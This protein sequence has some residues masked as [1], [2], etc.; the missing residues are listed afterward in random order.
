MNTSPSKDPLL[1]I[2]K[3]AGDSKMNEINL[4]CHQEFL[5]Q[6]SFWVDYP[7]TSEQSSENSAFSISKSFQNSSTINPSQLLPPSLTLNPPFLLSPENPRGF[8]YKNDA[9]DNSTIIYNSIKHEEPYLWENMAATPPKNADTIAVNIANSSLKNIHS[10]SNQRK[11]ISQNDMKTLFLPIQNKSHKVH[12]DQF[13]N[14]MQLYHT[15]PLELLDNRTYL[16]HMVE[17]SITQKSSDAFPPLVNIENLQ[18]NLVL[19]DANLDTSFLIT[20]LPACSPFWHAPCKLYSRVGSPHRRSYYKSI[21]SRI[22]FLLQSPQDSSVVTKLVVLSLVCEN[23]IQDPKLTKSE[24]ASK[25]RHSFINKFSLN[26]H[27][28][29]FQSENNMML[30]LS[31][32]IDINQC[33]DNN[34]SALLN[35]DDDGKDFETIDTEPFFLLNGHVYDINS[36]GDNMNEPTEDTTTDSSDHIS[37]PSLPSTQTVST[38]P[39]VSTIKTKSPRQK[40]VK[41][42]NETILRWLDHLETKGSLELDLRGRHRKRSPILSESEKQ[43][44]KQVF[45]YLPCNK[46]SAKAVRVLASSMKNSQLMDQLKSKDGKVATFNSKISSRK[47][48]S[49]TSFSRKDNTFA[50]TAS[51]S[52]QDLEIDLPQ[53]TLYTQSLAKHLADYYS[54]EGISVTDKLKISHA[55]AF[56]L[57]GKWG[58]KSKGHGKKTW[59]E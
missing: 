51:P 17:P 34:S 27:S 18:S 12:K 40:K 46:R 16:E 52:D 11:P 3:L 35:E 58:Y 55:T 54:S 10:Q 25:A 6:S 7:S 45:D 24:A 13:T 48:S 47:D 20:A 22:K 29:S 59:Y 38:T 56:A 57:I 43:F 1:Y 26:G 53:D 14:K 15:N 39:D 5:P 41:M 30:T 8:S 33:D 31:T 32:H 49:E 19:S 2:P 36:I 44:L 4:P 42:G 37:A 28:S 23:L 9:V 21:L 50:K